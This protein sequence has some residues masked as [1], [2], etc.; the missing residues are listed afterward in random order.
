MPLTVAQ[1]WEFTAKLTH[2]HHYGLLWP[3]L[4]LATWEHKVGILGD[5]T[6]EELS[7]ME[8]NS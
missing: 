3:V 6:E 4:F 8:Q 1:G 7:K 5:A 2:I